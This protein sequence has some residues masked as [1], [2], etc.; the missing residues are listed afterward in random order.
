L[1]TESHFAA[2][3]L[4]FVPL[5]HLCTEYLQE[6]TEHIY[7]TQEGMLWGRGRGRGYQRK[8]RGEREREKHN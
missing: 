3:V 5:T 2:L 8:K 4:Y 7:H 1:H 6:E